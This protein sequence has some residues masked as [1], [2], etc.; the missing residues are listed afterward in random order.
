MG[1]TVTAKAISHRIA[2]IKEKANMHVLR[3]PGP[4]SSIR[5]RTAGKGKYASAGGT[6]G[7][8]VDDVEVKV[9]DMD[10]DGD[11]K[12][13]FED[14]AQASGFDYPVATGQ[15]DGT[16]DGAPISEYTLYGMCPPKAEASF[17]L[18][19]QQRGEPEGERQIVEQVE[20]TD[21][22]AAVATVMEEEGVESDTV[23]VAQ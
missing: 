22:L 14:V 9:E 7:G 21:P 23:V 10:D 11:I 20:D 1:D 4:S 12:F 8:D 15:P 19:Q 13:K 5:R 2:K 18:R 6:R 16:V 3:D 17:E